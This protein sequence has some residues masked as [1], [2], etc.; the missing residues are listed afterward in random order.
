VREIDTVDTNESD[1][2]HCEADYW[3]FDQSAPF[4][5]APNEVHDVSC[6]FEAL[7]SALL[8]E[9]SRDVVFVRWKERWIK[10]PFRLGAS[11]RDKWDIFA[12][13]HNLAEQID[14]VNE[15][16]RSRALHGDV[17]LCVLRCE[18]VLAWQAGLEFQT[19]L[20]KL[21][22]F[23]SVVPRRMFFSSA[24]H[25]SAIVVAKRSPNIP[26]A[27]KT[28]PFDD[29]AVDLE[30]LDISANKPFVLAIF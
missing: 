11:N 23:A 7:S 13:E 12:V 9:P 25:I 1:I 27:T 6:S 20:A 30:Y 28:R 4:L 24:P 10:W 17:C 14:C 8:P 2:V 22:E 26:A 19:L 3:R 18:S 15:C 29:S 5:T 16:V 21:E